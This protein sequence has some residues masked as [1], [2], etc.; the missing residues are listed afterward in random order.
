MPWIDRPLDDIV[1]S[2]TRSAEQALVRSGHAPAGTAIG[3]NTLIGVLLREVAGQ[4]DDLHAHI[5]W[6]ADQLF[7]DSAEREFLERH[8]SEV[9][10]ARKQATYATG[11]VTVTGETGAVVPQGARLRAPAAPGMV[12]RVTADTT[13]V[14]GTADAPV[15]AETPGAA[16]NLDTGAAVAFFS[17]IA[18]VDG[19]AL[20]A[21]PGLAGGTDAETDAALLAR[22]LFRKR[23]P[24]RGGKPADY[25][26]WMLAV[27]GVVAAWAY[28]TAP[29]RGHVTGRFIRDPA[30][31]GPIP[32]E[33]LRLAVQA[34]V[35]GHINPVSG[36]PE[37]RPAGMEFHAVSVTG[38]EIAPTVALGTDTPAIRTAV[39]TELKAQ[40]LLDGAPG[41][42]VRRSRLAEAVSRAA[43]ETWHRLTLPAGDVA[44]GVNDYP[45]LGA[46]T[47]EAY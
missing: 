2:L 37:G 44:L 9:G 31:G 27:P 5:A 8:A 25:V 11:A 12:W 41:E 45:V 15:D 38:H 14:A 47:W 32:D 28:P 16:G 33:A 35:D 1:T 7:P 42:T 46:I 13:L 40:L 30:L 36:L 10:I 19:D 6:R 29:D 23:N 20:A 43:G 39:E 34:H 24:P 26:A 22:L 4:I 21:A 3:A 17:P 18:G